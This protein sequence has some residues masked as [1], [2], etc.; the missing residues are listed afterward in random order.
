MINSLS[1]IFPIFNEELRIN[2]SLNKIKKFIDV[3]KLKYIEI[4]FIDD[5]RCFLS[6]LEEYNDYPSI[7]FL[8]NWS[9][10][11]KFLWKIEHDIFIIQNISALTK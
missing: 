8:V 6:K 4:I 7:D 11:N 1:V 5:G 3:S 10:K 9:K 2:N